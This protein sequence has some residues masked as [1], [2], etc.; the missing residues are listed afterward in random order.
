MRKITII[1]G[2]ICFFTLIGS[3]NMKGQDIATAEQIAENMGV[4]L[5]SEALYDKQIDKTK[6]NRETLLMKVSIRN[7]MKQ[8]DRAARDVAGDLGQEGIVY[9]MICK[10]T[11]LLMGALDKL[12]SEAQKHPEQLPN[13]RKGITE[14]ISTGSNLV[15]QSVKIAMGGKVKNPFGDD[16][17]KKGDGH[18]LMLQD[19]RL[20]ICNNTIM[21]L[22]KLRTAAEVVAFKLGCEYTW[23]DNLQKTAGLHYYWALGIEE[24]FKNTVKSIE[25]APWSK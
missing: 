21:E 22:R 16:G 20:D 9:K 2:A 17:E 7:L 13:V 23:R 1:S 15:T 18:N 19:E 14:V 10:E 24:S 25:N 3:Q 5:G 11:Q 6:E 4:A 8:S 12:L